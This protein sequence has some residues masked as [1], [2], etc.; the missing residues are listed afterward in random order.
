MVLVPRLGPTPPKTGYQGFLEL[1]EGHPAKNFAP[2][3][4]TVARGGEIYRPKHAQ[5]GKSVPAFSQA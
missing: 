3:L 1:L 2:N 4:F 5:H